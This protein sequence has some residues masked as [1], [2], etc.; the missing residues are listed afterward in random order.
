MS[1]ARPWPLGRRGLLPKTLMISPRSEV[2][3][4]VLKCLREPRG[5]RQPAV[6]MDLPVPLLPHR[7]RIS[8]TG[9]RDKKR[10]N[11]FRR[12]FTTDL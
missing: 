5:R 11:P 4:F 7:L 3:H 12:P 10:P 6:S 2:H 9:I 8:E 1:P